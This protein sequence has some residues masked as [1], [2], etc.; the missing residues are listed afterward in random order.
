MG[1]PDGTV[2]DR[3]IAYYKARAKGGFGL[4]IV[5]GVAVNPTGKAIRAAKFW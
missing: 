1:N 4:I 3:M 5:E 2:S